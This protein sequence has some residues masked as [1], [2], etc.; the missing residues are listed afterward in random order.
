MT[1]RLSSHIDTFHFIAFWV[2]RTIFGC[3]DKADKDKLWSELEVVG[4]DQVRENLGLGRYGDRR[5]GG[6]AEWLR[7]EEHE[8]TGH[9]DTP[10]HKTWWGKAAIAIMII[11]LA[12]VLISRL[13]L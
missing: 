7:Q 8:R 5:K 10:W 2:N 12:A 13:G 6:V 3:V 1:L 9:H 11:V 4:E